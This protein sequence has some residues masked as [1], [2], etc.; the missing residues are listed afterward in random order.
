MSDSRPMNII[1]LPL[2]GIGDV[3]MTTPALR[4][5]KERTGARITYLHMFG[6]TR[7]I[8]RHNPHVDENIHFPFLDAGR[9]EALRFLLGFRKKFDVSINFY[10]SNRRDYSLAAFLIGAPKRL[11]HRYVRGDM[12]GLNFLKNR[13]VL[14]D[15][16]LHN[17]EENLRLLAF[18]GIEEPEPY[19]LELYLGEEERRF[20]S[21]WLAD[22]GLSESPLIGFHP[23]TSAFKE[24]YKRRWPPEKFS[25]LIRELGKRDGETRFLV[26]GGP[27]EAE[28]K[29]AVREGAGLE[30]RVFAVSTASIMESSALV[31][32]CRGFVTNDSGLLHVAAALQVPTVAVFGPTN[33]VWVKPWKCPH[34]VVSMGF[35]CSPCFRYSPAP[36]A[37]RSRMDFSC[38][39][40]V[41]VEEV[42]D[43]VLSLPETGPAPRQNT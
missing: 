14:E 35:G 23:G 29:E 38:V 33:P 7:D 36:L 39:R 43:A 19:P 37:C 20:A 28:L 11:G 32:M 26:F 40:D 10:P 34:R 8:L 22:R 41:S 16:A 42:L 2:Y 6:S 21:R 5:I 30:G 3:L 4:N 17:V 25:A 1:V 31:A 9:G 18:L 12:A 15:D 13:T 27:E 24:Q